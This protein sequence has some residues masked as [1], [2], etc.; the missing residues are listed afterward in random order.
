MLTHLAALYTG[1]G[2]LFEENF[3]L[4]V[5][6]LPELL[7]GNDFRIRIDIAAR[8][9]FYV[10]RWAGLDRLFREILVRPTAHRSNLVT[11]SRLS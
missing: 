1:R 6:I 10:S 2:F 11:H 4:W 8:S 9:H 5:V 3:G 7:S